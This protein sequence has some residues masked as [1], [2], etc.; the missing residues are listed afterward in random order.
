MR[1]MKF[2]GTSVAGPVRLR[3]VAGIVARAARRHEVAVVASAQ[4]GVTDAL[5]AAVDRGQRTG[6]VEELAGRH[7][8]G[9]EALGGPRAATAARAVRDRLAALEVL[10]AGEPAPGDRAAWRDSVLAAG[11]RL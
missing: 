2:G 3:Q 1:I 4:A 5:V 11:E 9:I 8:R 10:L 7:L 6:V